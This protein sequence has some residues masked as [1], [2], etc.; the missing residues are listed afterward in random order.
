MDFW[1]I[2]LVVT[3]F[4]GIMGWF[5][6]IPLSNC[7]LMYCNWREGV[8]VDWASEIGFAIAGPLAWFFALFEIILLYSK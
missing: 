4:G 5:F 1:T 8:D 3:C 7:L 2:L 6:T